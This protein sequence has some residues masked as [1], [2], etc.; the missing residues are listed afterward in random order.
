MGD[1]F[2]AAKRKGRAG[3]CGAAGLRRLREDVQSHDRGQEIV[4]R[5]PHSRLLCRCAGIREVSVSCGCGFRGA[6]LANSGE[7]TNR[8]LR[9]HIDFPPAACLPCDPS[10]DAI[11]LDAV[12]VSLRPR[13][14]SA[15]PT[16]GARGP[17]RKLR[18]RRPGRQD[19]FR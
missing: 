14:G 9:N 17:D 4:D 19:G 18:G 13:G 11:D 5:S 7:C 1:L 12:S 10:Q 3:V 2:Q 6:E 16:L 15:L 8:G